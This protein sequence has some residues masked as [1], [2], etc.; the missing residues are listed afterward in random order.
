MTH[1]REQAL[2]DACGD[3]CMYCGHRAPGYTDAE[4]PNAAGNYVHADMIVSTSVYPESLE[5]RRVLCVASS[6]WQRIAYERRNSGD[7]RTKE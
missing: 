4:G 6:I 5:R 2:R 3:V 1:E 7:S